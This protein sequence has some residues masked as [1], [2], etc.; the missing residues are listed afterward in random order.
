MWY[1]GNFGKPKNQ[2]GRGQG[3][4]EGVAFCYAKSADGI[5]WKKPNLGL[6]A[7]NGSKENNIVNLPDAT[8]KP[9]AAIL[10]E[11]DDPN[12]DRRFKMVY[13]VQRKRIQYCVAF[14]SDGKSWIQ[15]KFNPVGNFFEMSGI[16][17][18]RGKYY[19]NGQAKM[20]A[21]SPLR[22]R[23]LGTFVSKDFEHWSP[24]AAIGLNRSSNLVGPINE[25]EWNIDEEVHLGAALWNRKNVLVGIYGQWHGH[26]TGDRRFIT[27]DLGLC[28]SHDAIHYYEPIPD[29]KFIPAR[30]QPESSVDEFPALMQGQGMYN[31]KDKTYYWYST[32]KGNDGSAVR[33]VT[34]DRDRLGMLKPFRQEAK[35]ISCPIV[36][37]GGKKAQAKINASGLSQNS[38]LKIHLLDEGFQPIPGYSGENAAI[39]DND[40]LSDLIQWNEKRFLPLAKQLHFFIEFSGIRSED[41]KLHAIY[42]HQNKE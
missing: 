34:W 8:I 33:L 42:I 23:T 11:P 37:K 26:P 30:E 38:F 40:A 5:H 10:Y 32:W 4:Y 19:V 15:S 28:L 39:I 13:E 14:S 9:A 24:I 29:F 31:V 17:K 2:V 1:F 3:G 16:T 21:S 41:C 7:Y 12:P 6:V 22:I 27:M 20:A 35:V 18:F 25:S 36:V